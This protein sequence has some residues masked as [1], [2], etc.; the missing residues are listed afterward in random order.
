MTQGINKYWDIFISHASEDKDIV[1]KPLA[2]ALEKCGLRIWL[3]EQ[4]L[5]IG[6]SLRRKIDEGLAESRFGIV[7]LSK[8]FFAK[9]WPQKELD[10]LVSR[11]ENGEKVILPIWHDVSHGEVSKFSP[12]L[13]SRLAIST[14]SGLQKMVEEIL[15]A[16]TSNET[17]VAG[18]LSR[19]SVDVQDLLLEETYLQYLESEKAKINIDNIKEAIHNHKPYEYMTEEERKKD[20]ERLQLHWINKYFEYSRDAKGY[21]VI[22]V[23][24]SIIII[25][26]L[27]LR[28]DLFIKFLLLILPAIFLYNCYLGY[29]GLLDDVKE[30]D[31]NSRNP[32]MIRGLSIR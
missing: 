14:S 19:Y 4:Q 24:L 8:N 29:K 17:E 13:G 21:L 3:D 16:I 26:I 15:R 30:M 18:R 20:K 32:E 6:D 31:E 9:E 10:A 27:L 7:I 11:E 5:R 25:I 28:I 22:L 2:L 1:A 12:L 23:V